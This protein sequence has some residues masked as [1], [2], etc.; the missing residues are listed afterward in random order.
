M[1][2]AK[3]K[4]AGRESA[5]SEPHPGEGVPIQAPVARIAMGLALFAGGETPDQGNDS[6]LSPF[7]IGSCHTNNRSAEDDA[8]WIPQMAAIGIRAM[9]TCHTSWGNVEPEE[10]KLTWDALDKQIGAAFPRQPMKDSSGASQMDAKTQVSS[11][12]GV[13]MLAFSE[14]AMPPIQIILGSECAGAR[15]TLRRR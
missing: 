13:S 10:G 8:R 1:S 11:L 2:D 14:A 9:R 4:R 3:P 6:V 5:I 12:H 7:G 15:P